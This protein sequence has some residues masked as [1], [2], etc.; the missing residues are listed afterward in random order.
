MFLLF[1]LS[2]LLLIIVLIYVL[3]RVLW[4]GEPLFKSKKS[5]KAHPQTTVQKMKRDPVCG[6][7][8]TADQAIKLTLAKETPYF[9]SAECKNDFERGKNAKG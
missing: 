7:F 9:C 6:T 4:K 8:L 5:K 2:K 1:R 3:Y